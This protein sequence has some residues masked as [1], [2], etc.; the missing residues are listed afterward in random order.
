M[1]KIAKIAVSVFTAASLLTGAGVSAS[2]Q[3]MFFSDVVFNDEVPLSK[4]GNSVVYNCYPGYGGYFLIE[5]QTLK[6]DALRIDETEIFTIPKGVTLTVKAGA[7]IDGTLYIQE[8]G[9]LN[10]QGGILRDCGKIICDGSIVIGKKASISLMTCSSFLV[11]KSGSLKVNGGFSYSDSDGNALCLGTLSGNKLSDGAKKYLT[12]KPILAMVQTGKGAYKQVKDAKKLQ[13]YVDGMGSYGNEE[14][15]ITNI[16]LVLDN[17]SAFKINRHGN[18]T[19]II[20][21]TMPDML[22]DLADETIRANSQT[23]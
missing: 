13:S 20:E 10:V 19:N 23:E 1:N 5:N 18:K 16:T 4:F 7:H 15:K 6:K 14:G 11:N 3:C 12:A 8:G 2:A 9:K 17:G 22:I 21:R